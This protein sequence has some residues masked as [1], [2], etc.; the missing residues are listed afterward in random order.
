VEE[1]WWPVKEEGPPP[2]PTTTKKVESREEAVRCVAT[3]E[4]PTKQ[5]RR[6]EQKK[7]K[8]TVKGGTP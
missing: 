8:R 5:G 4:H 1:N 3:A 2:P 6:E 7:T